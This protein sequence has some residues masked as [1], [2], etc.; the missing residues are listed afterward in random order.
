MTVW[1]ED[2]PGRRC[3]LCGDEVYKFWVDK[4]PPPGTCPDQASAHARIETCPRVRDRLIG[5]YTFRAFMKQ[6]EGIHP[7]LVPLME[8]AGYT[9]E[10]L[11]MLAA[12]ASAIEEARHAMFGVEVSVD[13]KPLRDWLD[14]GGVTHEARLIALLRNICAA[15]GLA[16]GK[17]TMVELSERHALLH[18]EAVKAISCLADVDYEPDDGGE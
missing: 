7:K 17:R 12:R 5:S 14:D 4:E 3:N 8:K 16:D 18:D 11:A 15:V 9:L 6:G 10:D 13:G 2:H 1:P